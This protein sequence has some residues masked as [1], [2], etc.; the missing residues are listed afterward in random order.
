MHYP[1]SE[2]TV[3]PERTAEEWGNALVRTCYKS[4]YVA[5]GLDDVQ[6]SLL[7]LAGRWY[8]ERIASADI[9]NVLTVADA[10][11]AKLRMPDGH[12]TEY[13]H[14]QVAAQFSKHW[15]TLRR[16]VLYD[17]GQS[18]YDPS[19]ATTQASLADALF[20]VAEADSLQMLT[21]RFTDESGT[22]PLPYK[23]RVMRNVADD[24]R[25]SFF[26]EHVLASRPFGD[27][28]LETILRDGKTLF[29]GHV[30][31][32]SAYAD[33]TLAD[34]REFVATDLASGWEAH[35]PDQSFWSVAAAAGAPALADLIEPPV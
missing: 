30:E 13:D 17:F 1:R 21:E 32:V 19:R 9:Q 14:S 34:T 4:F 5:Q 11:F 23:G 12:T 26:R 24:P 2:Q 6:M 8:R 31:I 29:E 16:N 15:R 20:F 28:V 10:G 33:A 25:C 35:H 27:P 22:E 3:Q 7:P 18:S